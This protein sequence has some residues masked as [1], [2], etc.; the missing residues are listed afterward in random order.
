MVTSLLKMT[1]DFRAFDRLASIRLGLVL[2]ATFLA[3]IATIFDGLSFALIA[4]IVTMLV[5]PSS[6]SSTAETV[7]GGLGQLLAYFP[8]G[9]WALTI[10]LGVCMCSRIGLGYASNWLMVR[11]YFRILSALRHKI[12]RC[13]IGLNQNS[14][15]H[16][17][18]GH[19]QGLLTGSSVGMASKIRDVRL[20]LQKSA[21]IIAY[22]VILIR[23]DPRLAFLSLPLSFALAWTSRGVSDR[24][25]RSVGHG[26]DN[27]YGFNS[28]VSES[29]TVASSIR[30]YCSHHVELRKFSAISSALSDS[31]YR[32]W[33]LSNYTNLMVEFRSV[34]TMLIVLGGVGIASS[35]V[36]FKFTTG[37][38]AFVMTL[39][40]L[41]VGVTEWVNHAR[42]VEGFRQITQEI[43]ALVENA[44]HNSE[45]DSIH[46][47]LNFPA[48][49]DRLTLINLS[50]GIPGETPLFSN[51]NLE[52]RAGQN[53]RIRG[54]SGIGKS[55]MTQVLTR[56]IDP[57]EGSI[58]LNG[59]DADLYDLES[60]RNRIVIV[61][62][63]P[64]FRDAGISDVITYGM[65]S[66]VDKGLIDEIIEIVELRQWVSTKPIDFTIGSSACRLSHGQKLRLALAQA[67]IRKPA[68]LIL[69]EALNSVEPELA[70]RLLDNIRRFLPE[71]ILIIVSHNSIAG[72]EPDV[73]IQLC[74]GGNQTIKILNHQRARTDMEV[75]W[76]MAPNQTPKLHAQTTAPA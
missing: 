10:C 64:R 31:N 29:F 62:H 54:R 23:I 66:T 6:P 48:K 26:L 57:H 11:E 5:I 12:F 38:I 1:E 60:W 18:P 59:V 21:S 30:Q 69:D 9:Y 34:L 63:D 58:L 50:F 51:I 32:S 27:E 61:N 15:S 42:G 37:L 8:N 56:L 28:F 19:L 44:N 20:L 65:T 43:S 22:S 68:I 17:N 75:A 24:I 49:I 33:L 71:S 4:S 53:I 67:L 52:V 39:Q 41:M 16:L 25:K 14:F 72:F 55:T 40:R 13:A 45:L 47:G 73:E 46:K 76:P 35:M 36:E 3:F 2:G 74:E 7:T 70:K